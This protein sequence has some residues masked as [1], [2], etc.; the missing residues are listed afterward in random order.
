VA[1]AIIGA[2]CEDLGLF[3]SPLILPTFSRIPGKK[4]AWGVQR[5]PIF[6]NLPIF[7]SLRRRF[8]YHTFWQVFK[9]SLALQLTS[10]FRRHSV[11]V[12]WPRWWPPRGRSQALR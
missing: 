7:S 10:K 6:H 5:R 12:P 11:F 3:V 4:V 8:L 1:G 2:T 9:N